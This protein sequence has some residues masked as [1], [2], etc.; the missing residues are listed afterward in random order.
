MGPSVQPD[1]VMEG[2]AW[3]KN[4]QGLRSREH[5]TFLALGFPL[6][7]QSARARDA[8]PCGIPTAVKKSV[9][10]FSEWELNTLLCRADG[11]NGLRGGKSRE[12]LK[13]VNCQRARL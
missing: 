6:R 11:S 13:E 2:S 4:E 7:K 9:K 12:T 1:D 3:Q 10:K 8:I 5:F